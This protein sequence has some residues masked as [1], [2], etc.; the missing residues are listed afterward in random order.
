MFGVIKR[1]N[2]P[3]IPA[4]QSWSR[5]LALSPEVSSSST[6]AR[7]G[8]GASSAHGS[9]FTFTLPGA[10]VAGALVLVIEDND[11]NRKLVR[12]V[13]TFQRGMRVIESET[14]PKR[15]RPGW[16]KSGGPSLVLMDIR[17]ARD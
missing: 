17:F 10:T 16:P 12:D 4:R 8:C 5:G 14:G 11:K 9:T 1:E 3:E 2:R 6:A 13:L 15:V 7:S